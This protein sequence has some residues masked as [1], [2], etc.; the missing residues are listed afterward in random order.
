LEK[1][2]TFAKTKKTC[3]G[4]E[5]IRTAWQKRKRVWLFQQINF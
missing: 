3:L 1:P 2:K 4:L 5:T